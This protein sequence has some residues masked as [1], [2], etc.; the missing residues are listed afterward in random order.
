MSVIEQYLS[1]AESLFQSKNYSSARMYARKVVKRDPNNASA[2]TMLGL[3]YLQQQQLQEAESHLK[4]AQALVPAAVNVLAGLVSIS[5][6][7]EDHFAA[8]QLLQQLCD[9]E[10]T[11]HQYRYKL[12]MVATKVGN[13][14]LAEQ[15]FDWCVSNNMPEPAVML[16]LGHIHKA[17][18]NTDIAA[19]FYKKY[20]N[21]SGNQYGVG[22][23]SL[24]DLKRYQF[25]ADDI[26]ELERCAGDTQL[27]VSNHSLIQFAL[28]KAYEQHE[29]VDKACQAMLKANELMSSQRPFKQALFS[30]LVFS[31]LKHL[32]SAQIDRQ[33]VHNQTPIFIVGMPRS[34]TTLV[35]Q[36]LACHTQ[37]GATDELPFMERFALQ[38]EM[39]GGYQAR[40][41]NLTA[42]EINAFKVKYL[43]EVNHYFD[44]AP[45]YV[46]DKN[47]NNFLHIG[48]IKS[49]FPQAKIINVVRN[50]VDNGLSVFKQYFSHGHDYSYSLDGISTYWGHYL[51]IMAH[52]DTLYPNEILHV[53]F[54]QLVNQPEVQIQRMLDY[55][56]LE[57]QA[58]CFTFYESKRAVLTPSASQVRQPM[59]PKAIGQSDKYRDYLPADIAKLD[60]IAQKAAQQFFG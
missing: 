9:L 59:N 17:K 7:K 41:N 23:W 58:Q 1:Q 12:A 39:S 36:I 37:V 33:T 18:S 31:L 11:S 10:P 54:E 42:T 49:L 55:C 43:A 51:N 48:L 29:K 26:S 3:I 5:E 2:L 24:A 21:L 57:T 19:D 15:C 38:L 35:E 25:S 28:C 13:M 52:W 14:A 40:L 56:G 53:C 27:S 47:P 50:T 20:I 8:L 45:V 60:A 6:V 46:I 44:D 34:G 16:N 30:N 22:Y 4:A 32:P